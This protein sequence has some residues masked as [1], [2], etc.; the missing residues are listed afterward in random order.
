MPPRRQTPNSVISSAAVFNATT[1][2]QAALQCEKSTRSGIGAGPGAQFV[3]WGAAAP[4]ERLYAYQGDTPGARNLLIAAYTIQARM[5]HHSKR[6]AAETLS[7]L[8][9]N[10]GTTDVAE[11]Q[12]FLKSTE[13]ELVVLVPTTTEIVNFFSDA[14][15]DARRRGGGLQEPDTPVEPPPTDEPKTEGKASDADDTTEEDTSKLTERMRATLSSVPEGPDPEDAFESDHE[16]EPREEPPTHSNAVDE[17]PDMRRGPTFTGENL[18]ALRNHRSPHWPPGI[19][20]DNLRRYALTGELYVALM[21][22]MCVLSDAKASNTADNYNRY[23]NG[24]LVAVVGVVRSERAPALRQAIGVPS[25][26]FSRACGHVEHASKCVWRRCFLAILQTAST[27]AEFTVTRQ[28]CSHTIDMLR[29]SELGACSTVMATIVTLAP[30]MM[31]HPALRANTASLVRG[32]TS[33]GAPMRPG[34]ESNSMWMFAGYLKLDGVEDLSWRSLDLLAEVSLR[35]RCFFEPSWQNVLLRAFPETL[36]NGEASR[37]P[38]VRQFINM[39]VANLLKFLPQV[40]MRGEEEEDDAAAELAQDVR[41]EAVREVQN[42]EA[43]A[44]Q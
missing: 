1:M 6:S 35:T 43:G 24:R 32:M 30:T 26:A 33:I 21:L 12:E 41:D 13:Y 5:T 36:P 9:L 20:V 38:R 8:I 3:S 27:T 2:A 18:S 10:V 39:C 44:P 40:N 28:V 34:Q 23:I 16:E 37:E 14:E 25:F 4:R 17:Q 31:S 22:H 19:T 29:M 15:D 42:A 7:G 11:M